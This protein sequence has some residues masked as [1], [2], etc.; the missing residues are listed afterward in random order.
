L[1]A[2]AGC[3]EGEGCYH[4]DKGKITTYGSF[5]LGDSPQG[6][7]L[8]WLSVLSREHLKWDLLQSKYA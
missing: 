3:K 6:R 5:H 1:R 7:N 8:A 4:C 2:A